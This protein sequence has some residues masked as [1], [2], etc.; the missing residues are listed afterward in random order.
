MGFHLY[1]VPKVVKFME[2]N[3]RMVVARGGGK[4]GSRLRVL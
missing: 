1:E 3:N 4:E 2:T